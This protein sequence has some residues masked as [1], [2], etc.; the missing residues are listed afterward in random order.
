[1][2]TILFVNEKGGVGKTLTSS[3]VAAWLALNGA[4]VVLFDADGQANA[5][6]GL[7]I[8]EYPGV[9]NILLRDVP[10]EDELRRVRPEVVS[11]KSFSGELWVLPSNVESRDLGAR[12]PEH[13]IVLNRL[14]ELSAW[15]DYVIIDTAP[16]AGL[17]HIALMLASDAVVFPTI[18]DG[19]SIIG[20]R[21]A[22]SRLKSSTV[23][24]AALAVPFPPI[25]AKAIIPTRY[26]GNTGLHAGQLEALQTEFGG[27]VHIATPLDKRITWSEAKQESLSLFAYA[28]RSEAATQLS[29]VA[30][31]VA[32]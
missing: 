19:D 5:T 25:I 17:F 4:R 15:A 31:Y 22:F 20:V 9:V 1:M 16:S 23:L 24:R 10:W 8:P 29:K 12:L 6:T 30:E 11:R 27:K 14:Q 21:K 28:P 7:G 32:G 3:N 18:C 26:E 2:K 13:E